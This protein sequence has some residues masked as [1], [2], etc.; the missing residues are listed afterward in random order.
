MIVVCG[1]ALLVGV[2]SAFLPVTPV[3]PYVVAAVATTGEAAWIVGTAAAVGQTVGKLLIFCTARGALRSAWL[4][5]RLTK[6]TRAPQGAIRRWTAAALARLDQPRQA[7][8]I[9]FASAVTGIPPLLVAS[10]YAA[11]TPMSAAVFG[12]TCLGGRAIRFSVVAAAPH[13][14]G[15][16]H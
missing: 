10:V 4:R 11:R 9:L 5:R 3:E 7:V 1:T 2:V 15:F 12:L 6:P 13:L 16:L 8:P 14:L